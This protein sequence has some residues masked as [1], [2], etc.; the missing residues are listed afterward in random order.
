LRLS[1]CGNSASSIG[2]FLV[3]TRGLYNLPWPCGRLTEITWILLA[4]SLE[5][6]LCEIICLQHGAKSDERLIPLAPAAL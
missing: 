1:P 4:N 5:Q 3:D 6:N 2:R